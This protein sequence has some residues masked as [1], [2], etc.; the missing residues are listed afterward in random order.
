VKVPVPGFRGA[1][2]K[3]KGKGVSVRMGLKEAQSE[4][5]GRRT[6]TGSEVW[7]TRDERARDREVLH[8]RMGVCFINPAL[9]QGRFFSL[10]PGGLPKM[11]RIVACEEN[12]LREQRC[13]L[14]TGEKSAE[15]IV[16]LRREGPNGRGEVE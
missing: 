2:G 15:G 3:E 14:I 13:F 16:S 4:T 9:T 5:A 6:G 7:Y 11:P 1:E 8:P 10:T 12:W